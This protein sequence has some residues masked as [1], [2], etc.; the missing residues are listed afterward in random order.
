MCV[1]SANLYC[2]AT[3]PDV[4]IPGTQDDSYFNRTFR[5]NDNGTVETVSEYCPGSLVFDTRRPEDCKC[6]P[7]TEL[8]PAVPGTDRHIIHAPC[9]P[10]LPSSSST[11]HPPTTPPLQSPHPP[12]PPCYDF[13]FVR[14]Y[15]INVCR[16]PYLEINPKCIRKGNYK[17]PLFSAFEQTLCALAVYMRLPCD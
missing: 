17:A 10:P 4:L 14:D 15:Y 5:N 7:K 9:H 13:R 8:S 6:V 2:N 1:I 12:F 11:P 16:M 3:K